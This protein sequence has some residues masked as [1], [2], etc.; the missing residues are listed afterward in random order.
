LNVKTPRLQS[1]FTCISCRCECLLSS[2]FLLYRKTSESEAHLFVCSKYSKYDL[3]IT[4][5]KV[6][7]YQSGIF[8][9]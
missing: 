5:A 1:R 2:I 6:V 9:R 4:A 7:Y 8:N 3:F